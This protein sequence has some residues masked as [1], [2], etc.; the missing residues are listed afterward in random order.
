MLGALL[1]LSL[2]HFDI[3]ADVDVDV[4][5]LPP[6][7]HLH[8]M[9]ML[10]NYADAFDS[11]RFNS[12]RYDAIRINRCEEKRRE[13]KGMRGERRSST[14]ACFCLRASMLHITHAHASAEAFIHTCG[15]SLRF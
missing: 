3:D 10:I 1:L 11:I 7:C 4:E 6:T 14:M 5:N 9:L 15:W 12:I 13:E 8:S 2:F